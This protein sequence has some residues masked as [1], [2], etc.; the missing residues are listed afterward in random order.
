MHSCGIGGGSFL[1]IHDPDQ[2]VERFI[3]CRE[4]APKSAFRDMYQGLFQ[5][6]GTKFDS[7]IFFL[8]SILKSRKEKPEESSYGP[9]SIGI[10]GEMKC[11][12]VAHEK[13]GKLEWSELIDP[14]VDLV[15]NGVFVTQERLDFCTCWQTMA[16]LKLVFVMHFK[17]YK[18]KS[19]QRHQT[20]RSPTAEFRQLLV[21]KV[22]FLTQ[23]DERSNKELV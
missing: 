20:V 9:K 2:D 4:T 14:I 11:M 5:K 23:M 16:N 17:K 21:I 22:Y 15:R 19:S 7:K 13:F 6:L 1:V 10:P 18:N 12:S 8:K 3:N